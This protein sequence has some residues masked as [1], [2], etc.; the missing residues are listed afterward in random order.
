MPLVAA[1]ARIAAISPV[2]AR[3]LIEDLRYLPADVNRGDLLKDHPAIWL[4]FFDSQKASSASARSF[5]SFP[6]V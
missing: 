4:K 1:A 6:E 3:K 5:S 2:H